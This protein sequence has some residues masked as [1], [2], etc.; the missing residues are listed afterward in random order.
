M[1]HP[2][3]VRLSS[4]LWDEGSDEAGELAFDTMAD[5][6]DFFMVDGFVED[7]GCHVGDDGE[8]ENLYAHVAG[9]DDL[10]DGGHT[11]EIGAKG[12]EGADLGWGL[13]AWAEDGEIDTLV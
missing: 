1:G 4:Q 2:V 3:F 13:V 9:N 10:V 8:A 6:H 12:A 5:L 7:A 11:D